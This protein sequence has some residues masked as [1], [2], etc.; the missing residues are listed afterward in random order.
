MSP[1]DLGT[2]LDVKWLREAPPG[3]LPPPILKSA[4]ERTERANALIVTGLTL[5]CTAMAAL[6]LFLAALGS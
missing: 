3:Y 6:D 2:G 5:A 4:A 1:I